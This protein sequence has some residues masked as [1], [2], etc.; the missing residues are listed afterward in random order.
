MKRISSLIICAAALL[1]AVSCTPKS[2]SFRFIQISDP[3]IGFNPEDEKATVDWLSNTVDRIVELAPDFVICT[4]DMT[5]DMFSN[6]WQ[7]AAFDSLMARIPE[8][9]PVFYTPGNHDYRTSEW[10]GSREFYA[11]HFGDNKFCFMH[12][13]S[14]FIGFDSNL[15]KEELT[16]QEEEQFAWMESRLKE[17]GPGADH[18]FIFHHCPVVST[19][20]DEEDSYSNFPEPYRSKYLKLFADNDVTA[21]FTGHCHR[22]AEIEVDGVSLVNCGASGIPLGLS[23]ADGSANTH[24]LNVVEVSPK[25]VSWNIRP[26]EE[27]QEDNPEQS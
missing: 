6:D 2:Q 18:I 21:V 15:V 25:G 4:G 20:V 7:I 3:Q 9:I 14:L 12:K 16:G 27:G 22:C 24:C 17:L 8:S 10:P 13:G 19:A 11:G 23:N 1:A 26:V 5:H